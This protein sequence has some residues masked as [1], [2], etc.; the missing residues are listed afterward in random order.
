MSNQ[1]LLEVYTNEG[2]ED[3]V[4]LY[5]G[6]IKEDYILFNL[7]KICKWN[8]SSITGATVTRLKINGKVAIGKKAYTAYLYNE[9][10]HPEIIQA[11]KV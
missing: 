1:L 7:R 4:R 10:D 8:T 11:H 9:I 6:F 3:E 5:K 2:N